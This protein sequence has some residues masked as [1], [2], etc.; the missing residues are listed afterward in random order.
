MADMILSR[1]GSGRRNISRAAAVVATTNTPTVVSVS[2]HATSLPLCARFTRS[3]A[4][5]APVGHENGEL[6]EVAT[7][8]NGC[9]WKTNGYP[10]SA[11]AAASFPP[12]QIHLFGTTARVGALASRTKMPLTSNCTPDNTYRRVHSTK[13]RVS[14]YEGRKFT[15]LGILT[16]QNKKAPGL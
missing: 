13:S 3:S 9:V 14:T 5:S 7:A 12:A 8:C 11:S 4:R 2:E 10:G 6:L 15:L 1:I 16:V